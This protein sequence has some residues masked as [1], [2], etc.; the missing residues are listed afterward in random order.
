MTDVVSIPE[1]GFRFLKG[2]FQYS[3][4]VAAEPGYRI[5]RARFHRPVALAQAF[6]AIE[7][8]LGG[9]GRPPTAF[10]A[11]ELRSPAPMSEDE[12]KAFNDIYVSQLEKWAILHDGLNPIARTNVCPE[13]SPPAEVSCYAFSYTV[14]GAN[15]TGRGDFVSAGS[16]ESPEGKGNYRD[17]II[18]LGDTSPDGMHDKARWVLTE[19]ERRMAAV[20]FGWGDVTGTHLYTVHDV[21]PFLKQEFAARGAMP[22]GLNWHFVR[23]PIADL[24]FEMDVR[25]IARELVIEA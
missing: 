22:C 19:M 21:Y 9:L 15:E 18:R 20:G 16:G 12:F 11:C 23:P 6:D 13:V 17:H 25:S 4:A 1:R 24:E 7:R 3:A 14:E 5:E 10:C 8:H 2:V